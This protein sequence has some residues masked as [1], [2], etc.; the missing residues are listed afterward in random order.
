MPGTAGK[1]EHNVECHTACF[2]RNVSKATREAKNY[3][4]PGLSERTH[5]VLL[6]SCTVL[7]LYCPPPWFHSS[8]LSSVSCSWPE[9]APATA[10]IL[11]VSACSGLK[12]LL[13]TSTSLPGP[14]PSRATASP[15]TVMLLSPAAAGTARRVQRLATGCACRARRPPDKAAKTWR[16]AHSK[17]H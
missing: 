13:V 14:H 11:R 12:V 2:F 3:A 7:Y 1:A 4:K 15:I 16:Q 9:D 17:T 8:G 10:T 6:D 5:S